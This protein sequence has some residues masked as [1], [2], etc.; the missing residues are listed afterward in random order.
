MSKRIGFK[1]VGLV[2]GLSILACSI[3][4]NSGNP[5][6]KTVHGSGAVVEKDR[7]VSGVS[8]VEL[9]ME[10]TLHIQVGDGESLRIQAEDNLQQYIR[11]DVRA[12]T[13][14]INTADGVNLD[15]TRPID[16]YLTVKSLDSIVISSSG[17]IQAPDMKTGR[18]SAAIKSSGNLTMG[19]LDCSSLQVD[20]SSSGKLKM[21]ILTAGSIRVRIS[22][23]GNLEIAGGRV[24]QQ[25]ISISSSGEYRAGDLASAQAKVTLT[26][27][28]VATVRVSDQLSG[29]LSS[30]ANLYYIGSPAVNVTTS[31]SGKAVQ[32]NK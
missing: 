20:I 1:I 26:S 11:T 31:S 17:D 13:L 21:G 8:G 32:I 25:D 5:A 2:L 29:S 30:S 23:S 28:G 12:G 6:G 24:Q 22:S 7:S 10:G 27:S 15:S 18:F 4:A 3:T 9:A 19:N 14:V 16:Y